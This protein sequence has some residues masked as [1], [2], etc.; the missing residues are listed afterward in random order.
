MGRMAAGVAV[1]VIRDGAWGREL[2]LAL[3]RARGRTFAP[4]GSPPAPLAL[5]GEASDADGDGRGHRDPCVR[6]V[7]DRG[8]WGG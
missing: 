8:G 7:G 5:A 2:G 4:R 3:P 1:A 6:G